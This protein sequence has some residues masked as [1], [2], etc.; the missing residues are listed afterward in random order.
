MPEVD[1]EAGA[2]RT[3]L[4]DGLL[5]REAA[6]VAAGEMLPD[7]VT[8]P[9]LIAALAQRVLPVLPLLA[10]HGMIPQIAVMPSTPQTHGPALAQP[11]PLDTIDESA[12]DDVG[13][14][15]GGLL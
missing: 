7:G 3:L 1:T 5:I 9:Q 11:R 8:L 15:G 6:L 10:R 12:A 2:L 13:G 4:L 14:M